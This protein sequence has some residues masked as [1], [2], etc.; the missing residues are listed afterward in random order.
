MCLLLLSSTPNLP[1]A[2]LTSHFSVSA[3]DNMGSFCG[4]QRHWRGP[5]RV[6]RDELLPKIADEI[7]KLPKLCEIFHAFH[8]KMSTSLWFLF[9]WVNA[10]A[11]Q[12]V[13]AKHLVQ[14][15][16]RWFGPV[17]F[18]SK[19][20]LHMPFAVIPES[21]LLFWTQSLAFSIRV[22]P[23]RSCE[24]DS[25][26]VWWMQHL[27]EQSEA[28]RLRIAPLFTFAQLERKRPLF[29]SEFTL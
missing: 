23:H 3:A 29:G 17:V 20:S 25:G 14:F 21:S 13:P 16:Q 9:P 10:S 28:Q 7:V 18:T 4:S 12:T 15:G 6:C 24:C 22:S 11:M 27:L 26:R 5:S 1:N 2:C 8:A 19:G